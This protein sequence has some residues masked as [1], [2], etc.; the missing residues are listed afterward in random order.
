[1]GSTDSAVDE[2]IIVTA[3]PETEHEEN[4]SEV[5]NAGTKRKRRSLKQR[6]PDV[7]QPRTAFH[8][9][10]SSHSKKL[11][12]ESNGDEG[13]DGEKKSG[14]TT[15]TLLGKLWKE[16]SEEEKEPYR[17][18]ACQDKLRYEEK[19]ESLGH[20]WKHKRPK[21]PTPANMRWFHSVRT[22]FQEKNKCDY[23]TTL[24]SLGGQ[25]CKMT[26]EEKKPFIDAYNA[27]KEEYRKKVEE[28]K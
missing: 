10:Q 3:A 18:E 23:A 8:Y 15:S 26:D 4:V 27:E 14:A 2:T 20:K 17:K 21:R 5:V 22:E 6:F 12:A 24:K 7:I 1:M 9:F 16:L 28:Q 25:W 11:G 13:G 19:L